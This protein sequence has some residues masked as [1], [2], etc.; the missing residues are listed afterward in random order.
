MQ[1]PFL[2][3][4]EKLKPG[5]IIFRRRD[6]KHKNW[7]CRI[8]VPQSQ[9]YK[10]IALKTAYV[11]EARERAFDHDA[12]IRFRVTHK[13]P[14]FDKRFADVAEEYLAT[15]TRKAETGQITDAW[16]IVVRSQV[17][18]HLNPYL[19]HLQITQIG[20]AH[21]EEYPHWRKQN[22]RRVTRPRKGHLPPRTR[23]AKE[24]LTRRRDEDEAAEQPQPAKDG[25]IRQE[26]MTFRAIMNFAA[27][28]RYI[29]KEQVPEGKLP[30]DKA[31][32]EEF[33]A[34]E[35]RKL[36]RDARRWIKESRTKRDRWYRVMAYNFMLIMTNTGMRTSE[37]RNLKW[38]DLDTER[39]NK[40]GRRFVAVN[41][42]GKDKYR[43][44]VAAENVATY[45]QR[46]RSISNA[47]QMDDFVFC[48]IQGQQNNNLYASAI[49][50]L[51]DYA[52]LRISSSGSARTTYCFRHTYA[53]FRLMEGTDVYFLAKQM[54]TSVKMIEDY[55]GHITTEENTERILAGMPEW[56]SVDAEADR[57]QLPTERS[58]AQV[59]RG[60]A[61][62]RPRDQPRRLAGRGGSGKR[63]RSG[64]RGHGEPTGT[65]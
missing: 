34:T 62:D 47:T 26:M 16:R 42:R 63:S 36:H 49:E 27:K 3:D 12:D 8:K 15:L 4:V 24:A 23:R 61:R 38:R 17:T 54:G 2:M 40:Q 1:T 10:H 44:L 19:G 52:G 60:A 55:Y 32:R 7:Y 59:R 56:K 29:R 22:S 21:W 5:L 51:L 64:T 11:A 39:I 46:I 9:K 43:M 14:V 41:V 20:D 37:A 50:N 65:D 30:S 58:G 53:T 31:R 48:T 28:G 57:Q 25:T 6:V 45:L 13:V 35:Y 33:T 18:H